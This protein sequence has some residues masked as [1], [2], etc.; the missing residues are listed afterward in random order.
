MTNDE[1][2][3]KCQ[4]LSEFYA[5]AARTGRGIETDYYDHENSTLWK[6]DCNGPGLRSMKIHWR[7]KP[8]P[9]KAWVVWYDDGDGV[10]AAASTDKQSSERFARDTNG[11]I[12]EI[13]R[14]E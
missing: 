14:P 9:Q 3:K 5:E 4:W 11:I 2:K 1:Y 6:N 8:E 12:Q 7:L 13:T 10:I